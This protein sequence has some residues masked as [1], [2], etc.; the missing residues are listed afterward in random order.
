M[1]FSQFQN[2]STKGGKNEKM[3]FLKNIQS[4]IYTHM[5]KFTNE[6][7]ES[8]FKK[9]KGKILLGIDL[10]NINKNE[11][12]DYNRQEKNK[13]NDNYINN[14]SNKDLD[15]SYVS[16]HLQKEITEQPE[17]YLFGVQNKDKEMVKIYNR[18]DDLRN[19]EIKY[20]KERDKNTVKNQEFN[21]IYYNFKKKYLGL[22]NTVKKL[23]Q[24]KRV[25]KITNN[26]EGHSMYR[27]ASDFSKKMI[28]VLDIKNNKNETKNEENYL[29]DN[30]KLINTQRPFASFNSSNFRSTSS[31]GFSSTRFSSNMDIYKKLSQPSN[32]KQSHIKDIKSITERKSETSSNFYILII[33]ITYA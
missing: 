16:L 12:N 27:T 14:N 26:S 19:L 24:S 32:L 31:N 28:P 8:E 22:N 20:F 30:E 25:S 15:D 4:K 18:M 17:L 6:L 10:D 5:T 29:L 9:K 7:V 3:N 11:E 23:R 21:E 1:I 33:R 13:K 2:Y